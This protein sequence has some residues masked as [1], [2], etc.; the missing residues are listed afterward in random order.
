MTEN[1]KPN[2]ALE[3]PA[4]NPQG[5]K[6]DKKTVAVITALILGIMLFVGVLTQVVPRGAYDVGGDGAIIPA[7][8]D[9]VTGENVSTYAPMPD[10]KMPFWKTFT[11][12]IEVFTSDEAL[13]GVAII[14]F[15]ILIGG[16]FLILEKSGVLKYIL[17]VIVKKFAD[18]K[19]RLLP[20]MIL[21]MMALSSIVGILEESVTLV[22]LCVAI[23]LALGWDSLVGISIS[24][25]SVAFGYSAALFNP[26]NVG[27]VQ[28]MAKLPMFS[29]LAYRL[30]IF[31][32][33]Y[34][35]LTT[36]VVLYAKKIE[37]NP[38][39]SIVYESDL[40]L[41]EKYGS[42]IDE[43]IV[44]DPKMRKATRTFVGC[45]GGV[46]FCAA[47]SFIVQRIEAV[48]EVIRGN[49]DFL[50]MVAMAVLF[51]VGGL[52]AGRI[53][54]IR[55]KKL[56]SGFADGAKAIAPIAPLIIFV[57]AIT[58]ILKQGMIIDTILYHVYE[59]IKGFGPSSAL[60]F[61]F[62]FVLALEF[63]IGS[64]TAK[65]FLIMPLVL[66]LVDM[67]GVSRQSIVIA[68]CMSDGFANILYPTS[69]VM[70]IAIGLVNVSYG[71]F[72]RFTWKLF[73]AV[74][75]FAALILLGAVAMGY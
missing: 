52:S 11:A 38:R 4:G 17:S 35:I 73:A 40:K 70:L 1:K 63:F 60:L 67:V 50:P 47:V 29:G 72:M 55:G 49:I 74:F 3:S 19:Y 58:F 2:N 26:F 39:K 20:I 71:K 46:L 43:E 5:L 21:A 44:R 56:L 41:R 9:P 15:I 75:A 69:G 16:T 54:G 23:S 53:V 48:P 31:F 51:T 59:G 68:F 32:G 36:F 65:A 7:A 57:M 8:V 6:L 34:A 64:G 27:L 13:T 25:I 61:I 37:K 62:L 24:L 45:I 30:V 14:L 33:V 22:P 42:G 66:P 28:S 12:P 10:F 18:K